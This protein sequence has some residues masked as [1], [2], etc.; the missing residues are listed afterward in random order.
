MFSFPKLGLRANWPLQNLSF[1][2]ANFLC[3]VFFALFLGALSLCNAYKNIKKQRDD[4]RED[5]RTGAYEYCD[6]HNQLRDSE[7]ELYH[8]NERLQDAEN[9]MD[10]ERRHLRNTI[11]ELIDQHLVDKEEVRSLE[12]HV[13]NTECD[14]DEYTRKLGYESRE[15]QKLAWENQK[16]ERENQQL[17]ASLAEKDET[18]ND[19]Q[20]HQNDTTS[21]PVTAV[22]QSY[23]NTQPNDEIE[24]HPPVTTT[25]PLG[26]TAL[27]Q[28]T[29]DGEE[30]DVHRTELEPLRE[31]RASSED[32]EKQIAEKDGELA[33]R[34]GRIEELELQNG[35][36]TSEIGGLRTDLKNL[37]DEHGECGGHL[38][39]QLIQKDEEMENLRAA[40]TTVE[41]ES[42]KNIATLRTK[43]GEME[44]KVTDL[45]EANEALVADSAPPAEIVQRLTTLGHELEES[46]SAHAQCDEKSKSQYSTI[47]EL[48]TAKE[49]LEE[50]LRLKNDEFGS[51]QRQITPV[52]TELAE[53]QE[54]HR[55]CGEHAN[56]QGSE[57]TKLRDANGN[58][59]G[60]NDNLLRQ[61]LALQELQTGSQRELWS[62]QGQNE[63]LS[64]TVHHQQ[65]RIHTLESN[66]PTCQKLRE[67]LDEVMKDVE[68]SDDDARAAMER[69][70]R[71]SVRAELR[72]QVA[73]DLRR[74][75][76]GEV[77]HEA[78]ERFQNHYSDLLERNTKRIR[79]QDRL[80]LEKDAELERTK[81][82]PVVNQRK[83]TNLQSTITKLQQDTKIAKEKHSRSSNGARLDR[84]QLNRA[85]TT[86]ADLRNELETIKADQ[87]RAQNINPLQSKLTT[88]QRELSSMKEDRNKARDNCSSYS[89]FLSAE[90]KKCKALE[91]QLAA[92]Q[93]K[94]CLA[95]DS[96]MDDGRTEG[97]VAV[98]DEQQ[99]DIGKLQ[100]EVARLSKE[101]EERKARDNAQS[102]A[103]G[104]NDAPSGDQSLSPEEGEQQASI[105]T[106][107]FRLRPARLPARQPTPKS[108]LGGGA[109]KKR[110]HDEFSDG[111][112]DDE[113][114]DRKKVKIDEG[115]HR[116]NKLGNHSAHDM[117]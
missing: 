65:Q 77:E 90:K 14:R 71:A 63:T 16:L 13:S 86:I 111:E 20:A 75:V 106:R 43:L 26:N 93:E 45:K 42:A 57:I 56:I 72:S 23:I 92:F 17:E 44:K 10:D 8:A 51:L 34:D 58:L 54:T 85:Q 83:E 105:P 37:S 24:T 28:A 50:T 82:A 91:D 59:Q 1:F 38:Q 102:Q 76:R 87:R 113:G 41:E 104:N 103:V 4:A 2:L 36:L 69:E 100:A 31:A 112:A 62:L 80:I 3:T 78:H 96:M 88:C 66:C 81:N 48:V 79:E 35:T 107:R 108:V 70:I 68:M 19:L 53:L 6:L 98:Q 74:Q 12:Q 25:L 61:N 109:G 33:E 117:I 60:N 95:G 52:Q 73:D 40:K 116:L 89:N 115:V 67:A 55:K 39:T 30:S 47:E 5:S 49:Q 46:R 7:N 114:E 18:I 29:A 97:A 110:I 32:L 21:E 94:S 15:K 101:L 11:Q 27:E 22:S 84:E 9:G 64:Q 99:K